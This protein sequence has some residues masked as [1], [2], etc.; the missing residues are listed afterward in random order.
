MT[1][2][3]DASVMLS[4]F[5][6]CLSQSDGPR[7]SAFLEHL[8]QQRSD[9]DLIRLTA[10][11]LHTC[12][13]GGDAC[14]F[15][16]SMPDDVLAKISMFPPD[17]AFS[18]PW[19]DHAGNCPMCEK[20]ITDAGNAYLKQH[21]EFAPPAEDVEKVRKTFLSSLQRLRGTVN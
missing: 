19:E 2:K 1:Q 16:A 10:T 15:I 14:E 3:R 8:L 4:A 13:G 11:A 12:R 5:L 7:T 21:P 9:D 17:S 20:R 18:D 6:K